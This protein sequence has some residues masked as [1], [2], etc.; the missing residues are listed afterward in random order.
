MFWNATSGTWDTSGVTKSNAS[1]N[2]LVVAF[3]S[4]LTTFTVGTLVEVVC[5]VPKAAR[6]HS[7]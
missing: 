2:H 5:D 1:T 6:H 4:H 3:S 7:R